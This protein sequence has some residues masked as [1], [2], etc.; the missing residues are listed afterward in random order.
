MSSCT[1]FQLVPSSLCLFMQRDDDFIWLHCELTLL[2][3]NR[4]VQ[5]IDTELPDRHLLILNQERKTFDLELAAHFILQLPNSIN[6]NINFNLLFFI[7]E[8]ISVD[9]CHL[10]LQTMDV[11]SGSMRVVYS[12][13][14]VEKY[15]FLWSNYCLCGE[16]HRSM[17][18]LLLRL[19]HCYLLGCQRDMCPSELDIRGFVPCPASKSFCTLVNFVTLV[20]N[21]WSSSCGMSPSFGASKT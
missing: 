4:I 7:K 2:W 17:M 6:L 9:A 15:L 3:N 21:E 11:S 5:I 10:D 14:W 8:C 12:C 20:L 19:Y 13:S 1:L 18:T 16:G